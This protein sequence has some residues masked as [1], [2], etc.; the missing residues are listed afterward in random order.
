MEN[1][2]IRGAI[3]AYSKAFVYVNLGCNIGH[4][5]LQLLYVFL[6]RM[7]DHDLLLFSFGLS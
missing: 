5:S 7:S 6:L 2:F 4:L 3:H 1:E